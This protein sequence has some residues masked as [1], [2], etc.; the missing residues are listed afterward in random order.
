MLSHTCLVLP[1]WRKIEKVLETRSGLLCVLRPC[2]HLWEPRQGDSSELWSVPC[3]AGSRAG[4]PGPRDLPRTP[5]GSLSQEHGPSFFL[6][7]LCDSQCLRL[8]QHCIRGQEA[9][10]ASVTACGPARW[11]RHQP[12]AAA[13]SHSQ[14]V[15]AQ[16]E[17]RERECW[18][19]VPERSWAPVPFPPPAHATA[20]A[21]CRGAHW[22]PLSLPLS[23]S[24]CRA[25]S[26]LCFCLSLLWQEIKKKWLV[27]MVQIEQ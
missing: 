14:L 3:R 25:L 8:E 4:C 2:L 17:M 10:V 11:C 15:H 7:G 23:L 24:P 27:S 26:P 21:V 19:R 13:P 18:G 16:A 22:C 20:Q 6:S 1:A 5:H 9:R 12:R